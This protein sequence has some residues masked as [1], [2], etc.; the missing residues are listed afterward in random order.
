MFI[1]G[2]LEAVEQAELG[3][4]LNNGSTFGGMLF[5]N[6]FVGVCDSEEQLLKLIDAVHA[7][8]S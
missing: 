2:L 6:D 7:Y 5:A 8:C 3:I 4:D 1:N